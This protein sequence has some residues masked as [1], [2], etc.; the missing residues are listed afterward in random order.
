MNVTVD[1]MPLHPPK[2][3]YNKKKIILITS[4]IGFILCMSIGIYFLMTPAEPVTVQNITVPK[5][6]TFNTNFTYEIGIIPAAF[7]QHIIKVTHNGGDSIDNMPKDLWITIYPPDSTPYLR[8]TSVIHISKYP[9]FVEG[10]IL[11]IY[12]G[13][14][15]IFYAS[16][17]LPDYDNYVDFPNGNWGIHIDD[18]RYKSAISEFKFTIENSKTHL[19]NSKQNVRIADL[20]DSAQPFDTI[21]IKGDMIYHERLTIS[22]KPIRLY[23]IDN[24]VIDAGAD[25]SVITFKNSSYSEISG[26]NIINSGTSNPED[27][28]ILLKYS[29]HINIKN[30][31]IHNNQNGIYLINSLNNDIR[32]NQIYTNDITGL[33][34][35]MNSNSNT[36]KENNFQQNTFGIYIRDSSDTNYIVNNNGSGNTRFGILIDNKLKNVY[37]YNNFSYDIMSYNRVVEQNLTTFSVDKTNWD[38]WFSTCGSHESLDS[39][40]CKGK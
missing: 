23:S 8:R 34:L 30:N 38:D 1:E 27:S 14:D 39:P 24:A 17:E 15:Q 28:G 25:G 35:V 2:N 32:Y 13:K 40:A 11:Y 29:D 5:V 19:V 21:F 3:K 7:D 12:L 26:F 33:S 22:D 37:E 36:I 4:I 31:I 18:A 10:D 20:I 9:E 16:K 6:P